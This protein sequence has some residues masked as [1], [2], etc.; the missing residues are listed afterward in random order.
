MSDEADEI[1]AEI[2]RRKDR[3]RELGGFLELY[4]WI[5]LRT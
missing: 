1:Y 2:K 4:R 5:F 3:A